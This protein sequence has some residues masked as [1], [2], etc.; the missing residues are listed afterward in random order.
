MCLQIFKRRRAG[1][2]RDRSAE[3]C[4]HSRHDV[5]RLVANVHACVRQHRRL[6][7]GLLE[8][9]GLV[10]RAQ[11]GRGLRDD[12]VQV[13]REPDHRE[14]LDQPLRVARPAR[15]H[16]GRVAAALQL[17]ESILHV[18][19]HFEPLGLVDLG[20]EVR[21]RKLGVLGP[22]MLGHAEPDVVGGKRLA[23][24]RRRERGLVPEFVER[25]FR[26]DIQR[27]VDIDQR[28]VEI[29]KDRLEFAR[30]QM[31]SPSF[32]TGVCKDAARTVKR[33]PGKGKS[34]Y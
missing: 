13:R 23:K 5:A 19:Q 30:G 17:G 2:D 1:C 21:V 31:N 34:L 8:A 20:E 25:V 11:R 18:R 15:D 28:A 9:L 10:E 3:A 14:L 12:L 26:G 33:T 6:H 4:S 16:A 22:Q 27:S 32:P 29:E 24:A 7:R